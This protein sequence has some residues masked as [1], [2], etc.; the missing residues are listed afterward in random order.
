MSEKIAKA[1][2]VLERFHKEVA[3]FIANN[4]MNELPEYK[5]LQDKNVI[6]SLY[7]NDQVYFE[8]L[9]TFKA[10]Y[11]GIKSFF[12]K[13]GVAISDRIITKEIEAIEKLIDEKIKYLDA[14]VVSAKQRVK[15]YEDIIYLV[16]NMSYGDY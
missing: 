3:E 6:G 1:K 13:E 10:N 14:L 9:S 11:F 15:F 16:S 5:K 2:E 4:K 7:R 8:K 12:I